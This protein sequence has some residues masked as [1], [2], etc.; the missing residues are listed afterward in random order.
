[1]M[2]AN[3]DDKEGPMVQY[4]GILANNESDKVQHTAVEARALSGCPVRLGKAPL[5]VN[6]IFSPC[7]S[8]NISLSQKMM[9]IEANP[10]A[11]LKTLKEVCGSD[12]KWALKHL[13]KEAHI[14]YTNEVVP[15][16]H[17]KAGS[18]NPWDQL[19]AEN[20]QTL[21][22][23]VFGKGQYR[24]TNDVVLQGLVRSICHPIST[25]MNLIQSETL[26]CLQNWCNRFAQSTLDVINKCIEANKS[27]LNTPEAIAEQVEMIRK[28]KD[29]YRQQTIYI[30]IPMG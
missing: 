17:K 16:V 10:K 25:L 22:D 9:K 26:S 13:T 11:Q 7:Q 20:L 19:T 3:N 1:M 21:I 5:K 12:Y 6:P 24:V 27:E 15:L 2:Q 18:L 29:Y 8:A 4:G 23:E 30:C 14:Q 28:D